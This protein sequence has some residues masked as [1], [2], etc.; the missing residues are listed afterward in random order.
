MHLPVQ[1]ASRPTRTAAPSTE[2]ELLNPPRDFETPESVKEY[3]SLTAPSNS[4]LGRRSRLQDEVTAPM[5]IQRLRYPFVLCEVT[6]SADFQTE[7][8]QGGL[9]IFAGGHPGQN[10]AQF[11]RPGRHPYVM[12][13]PRLSRRPSKWARVALELVG[14]ELT[15][16]TLVA[17]PRCAADWASTPAFPS[18]HPSEAGDMLTQRLR[19]KLER[20]GADL[21]IWFM[22]PE[23]QDTYSAAPT[24]E[25]VRRRW[26]KCREVVDF[27]DIDVAKGDVWVGCYAGRPVEP[28]DCCSG[29]GLFVEFEDFEVL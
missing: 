17:N 28:D 18:V 6:V 19:L 4:R 15:V 29:E 16:S 3:F 23:F 22:H 12:V 27:F 25:A 14:G 5:L 8:D 7:W 10:M 2:Y 1:P 21:W 20:V 13:D 24:P 11:Q 26:R 9:V